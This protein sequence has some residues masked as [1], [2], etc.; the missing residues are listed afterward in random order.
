MGQ[1][2][3]CG[4]HQAGMSR[5]NCGAINCASAHT[6]EIRVPESAARFLIWDQLNLSCMR[7]KLLVV[8][9]VLCMASSVAEPPSQAPQ[10]RRAAMLPRAITRH[11]SPFYNLQLSG[12][13]DWQA[14]SGMCRNSEQ[15]ARS[16]RAVNE[17]NFRQALYHLLK[18]RADF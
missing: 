2:D 13:L 10:A 7:R 4:K 12:S 17:Q 15:V 8:S 9:H 18:R 3:P 16:Q 6:P 14:A 1:G 11:S 5:P